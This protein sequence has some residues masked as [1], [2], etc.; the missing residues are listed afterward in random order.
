MVGYGLATLPLIEALAADPR[1]RDGDDAWYAD[2]A[3]AM[4]GWDPLDGYVDALEDI[5]PRS[6]RLLRR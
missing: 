2:D 3:V 4:G 6:A 1:C 5:G